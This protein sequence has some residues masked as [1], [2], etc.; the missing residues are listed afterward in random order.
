[1]NRYEIVF[2][3]IDGTFLNSEHELTSRMK[4]AVRRVVKLN[5]PFVLASSRMPEAIFPILAMAQLIQPVICYG[6]G[7]ILDENGNE[8]YSRAMSSETACRVGN[9][10]EENFRQITWNAYSDHKWLCASPKSAQVRQEEKITGIKSRAGKLG[11]VKTWKKVHK[12]LC[13]GDARSISSLQ[14]HCTLQFPD[15]LICKSSDTYLEITAPSVSKGE[16]LEALC[17]IKGI[18]TAG[19]LAFGDNYNDLDMLMKAGTGYAMANAPEEIQKIVGNTAPDNDH[20]GIA[21][22]L[23]KLF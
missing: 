11:E 17:R 3:D 22:V 15:L 16:A 19:A 20:D 7:L 18:S 1:M 8:L 23:E 9:Y 12:L 5:I 2:T 10:I 21:C 13:M 4:D 6:G 14:E